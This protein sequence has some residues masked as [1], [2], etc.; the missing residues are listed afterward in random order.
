M[1]YYVIAEAYVGPNPDEMYDVDRIIISTT[2]AT[3]NGSGEICLDGWAGTTGDW[4]VH[5]FGEFDTIEEARAQIALTFG[6]TR[7][8]DDNGSFDIENP[9]IIETH[10]P[11]EY[12][13]MTRQGTADW[14]W[15]SM[16][17]ITH[18]TT[19]HEL[20]IILK[21]NE[22]EVN[23]SGD[24]LNRYA[25]DMLVDCRDE[26]IKDQIEENQE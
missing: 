11:G 7:T 10:K 24:T 19:D 25:W 15:A 9:E 16:R 13:V 8:K 18:D 21:Q 26:K 17:R 20:E 14:L 5:A 3:C 1:K 4:A 6:I 12:A 22:L 2:P 23:L